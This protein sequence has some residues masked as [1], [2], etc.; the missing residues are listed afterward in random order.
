M[1]RDGSRPEAS[2]SVAEQNYTLLYIY[3][4]TI[5]TSASNSGNVSMK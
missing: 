4:L 3:T 2:M 1:R 5:Y